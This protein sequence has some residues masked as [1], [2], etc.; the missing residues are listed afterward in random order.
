MYVWDWLLTF[1]TL[2]T[3]C[4]YNKM[5]LIVEI[6]LQASNCLIWIRERN[7]FIKI[8][9]KLSTFSQSRS[10]P[11][12]I[13]IFIRISKYSAK[14]S[15]FSGS[16]ARKYSIYLFWIS[17]PFIFHHF[18]RARGKK[19][20]KIPKIWHWSWFVMLCSSNVYSTT[21]MVMSFFFLKITRRQKKK[22]NWMSQNK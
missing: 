9:F 5:H 21:T 22:T 15:T 1:H 20:W 7:N 17:F 16:N 12:F 2:L 6:P 4:A 18:E 14:A 11:F 19:K 13:A 10:R 8:Q 3:V